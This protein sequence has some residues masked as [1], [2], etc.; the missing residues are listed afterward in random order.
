MLI[1]FSVEN[2]EVFNTE[3]E[4]NLES[5]MR[6]KKFLSNV[7]S[8][9]NAATNVVKSLAIYGPNNTGKSCFIHAISAFK[10][11]LLNE[12]IKMKANLFT[13]SDL[14][15]LGCS[16]LW[17]DTKYS[18]KFSYKASTKE[19][20]E[21]EFSKYSFDEYKNSKKLI[22]FYRNTETKAYESVDP[23]L[24]DIIK[25]ASK[26]SILIYAF[27]SSTIS[28]LN[29]AKIALTGIANSIAVISMHKL[30]PY[31]TIELLKDPLSLKAQQIVSLI[32]N[33][34][35]DIDDF[36]YDEK[37]FLNHIEI[38]SNIDENNSDIEKIS[39]V[40]KLTSTHKGKDLP[41]IIFDSLGTKK[42]VSL[43]GHIVELLNSGGTLFVDELDSGLH[44]KITR[45]I[46]SL[47]NN[48]INKNAQLIFTTHDSSLLD[49]K[50][51]FRKEQIWFTDKDTEQTYLYSLANFTTEN[52]GLR[53]D[54]NLYEF[55]SKGILGALP[56]PSLINALLFVK[57]NLN[58]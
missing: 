17:N 23:E 22:L 42:I 41:S 40:L 12:S 47:F 58:E 15:K 16:F 29:E 53:S 54:S 57:E 52:S 1:N 45:E 46:I 26:D 25:L 56:D 50:T 7:Y 30:Q 32:K 33:A 20:I 19:F 21:E 49:I 34:D 39:D 13:E 10:A 43:A 9:Q 18:Y 3:V 36:K 6:T 2:F 4:L 35:L 27:D 55:Y 28:V 48:L 11:I 51:L 38:E 14:I 5:D 31:K 24:S 8:N 44:F 37:Y